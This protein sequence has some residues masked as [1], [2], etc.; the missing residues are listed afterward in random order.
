MNKGHAAKKA[1]CIV[2]SIIFLFCFETSVFA[3]WSVPTAVMDA[4]SGIVQ[5]EARRNAE[6]ATMGLGFAIAA[7]DNVYIIANPQ[8]TYFTGYKK[9][10][11][12]Y[13]IYYA[14]DAYVDAELIDE[15]KDLGVS[16]L[17]PS[18]EIPGIVPLTLQTKYVDVGIDVYLYEVLSENK[19]ILSFDIDSFGVS[20]STIQGTREAALTDPTLGL[21]QYW[22]TDAVIFIRTIGS[23]LLDSKGNV[24]GVSVMEASSKSATCLHIQELLNYIANAGIAYGNQSANSITNNV[25]DGSTYVLWGAVSIISIAIIVLGITLGSKAAKNKKNKTGTQVLLTI[26]N[27]RPFSEQAVS[28]AGKTLLQS[29]FAQ[30]ENILRGNALLAVDNVW[31]HNNGVLEYRLPQ[32]SRQ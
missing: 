20:K 16:I 12:T 8:T 3:S 9:A 7:N 23:P 32:K 11:V 5:I 10:G 25:T 31:Y 17:R 1:L 2:S 26:A 15:S 19:N 14:E 27:G 4:R 24:V 22:K 21:V 6:R 30:R 18:D 13:R 29:L 28:A